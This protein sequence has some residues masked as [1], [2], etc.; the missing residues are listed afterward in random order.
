MKIYGL[1]DTLLWVWFDDIFLKEIQPFLQKKSNNF[2]K[3]SLDWI[4]KMKIYGSADT[5]L[6]VVDSGSS[7]Q[8]NLARGQ[9]RDLLKSMRNTNYVE[10]R[11]SEELIEWWLVCYLLMLILC[12][13]FIF[14]YAKGMESKLFQWLW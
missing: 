10:T 12:V 1:S 11:I 3:K 14:D 6:W 5:P 8:H 7:F 4:E 2:E 13:M 9:G